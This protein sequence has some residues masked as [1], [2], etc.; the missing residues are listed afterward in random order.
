MRSWMLGVCMLLN[1]GAAQAEAKDEVYTK[2]GNW[3]LVAR[4]NQGR[5]SMKRLYGS[6]VP[7]QEQALVIMYN[8]RDERVAFAW[9]SNKPKFLPAHGSINL[10]LAFI[11][12]SGLDE[13]WGSQSFDYD[14]QPGGYFLVHVFIGSANAERILHDL[15]SN[16]GLSLFLGPDVLM[17]VPLDAADAVKEL[18]RCALTGPGSVTK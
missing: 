15:A 7:D 9:A 18:R 10:D 12:K 11:K 5:C 17:G 6:V 4:E 2:V 1:A 3:E 16:E 14:K 8:A 13:S